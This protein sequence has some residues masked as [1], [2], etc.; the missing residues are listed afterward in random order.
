MINQEG[1]HIRFNFPRTG[2]KAKMWHF[3]F[4]EALL[5][6]NSLIFSTVL[7]LQKQE[8]QKIKKMPYLD[9]F[10]RP[11]EIDP[12]KWINDVWEEVETGLGH[13]CNKWCS[14]GKGLILINTRSNKVDKAVIVDSFENV[15]QVGNV[16][17]VDSITSPALLA[18]ARTSSRS[19]SQRWIP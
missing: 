7:K 13:L 12:Y 17:N 9:Q 2:K 5:W 8:H 6:L 18:R 11:G 15:E 19:S 4:F 10:P 3:Y 1:G 14:D 16:E